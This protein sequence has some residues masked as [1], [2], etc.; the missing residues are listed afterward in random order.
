MRIS[1]CDI[2][3]AVLTLQRLKTPTDLIFFFFFEAGLCHV[4]QIN[5]TPGKSPYLHLQSAG[6][7]AHRARPG[8]LVGWLTDHFLQ[9]KSFIV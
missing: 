3:Y 6:I 4:A 8:W 7:L 9:D 2:V 5:W 1:F